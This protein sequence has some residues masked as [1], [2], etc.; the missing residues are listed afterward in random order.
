MSLRAR[1]RVSD[2]PQLSDS[3]SCSA[4]ACDVALDDNAGGGGGGKRQ[5]NVFSLLTEEGV[6][7]EEEEGGKGGGL[8]LGQQ[9]ALKKDG[10]TG[11]HRHQQPKA[12]HSRAAAKQL[13]QAAE[14][15]EEEDAELAGDV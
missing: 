12:P 2:D 6:G 1:R 3:F 11:R 8:P 4:A 13:P 10:N 5:V 15:E 9:S 14:E 7:V